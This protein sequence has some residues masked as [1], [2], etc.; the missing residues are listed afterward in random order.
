MAY[1]RDAFR[2]KRALSHACFGEAASSSFGVC[3][4]HRCEVDT[5][6]ACK[7]TVRRQL[8]PSMQ[9]PARYVCGQRLDDAA[10]NRTLAIS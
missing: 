6:R 10:I 3:P 5:K 7:R 2:N 4:R 1:V 8:L 9:A